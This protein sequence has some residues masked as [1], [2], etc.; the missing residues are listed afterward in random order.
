MLECANCMK[1]HSAGTN[2]RCHRHWGL[3]ARCGCLLVGASGLRLRACLG[4]EEAAPTPDLGLASCWAAAAV[5]AACLLVVIPT[6]GA[7]AGVACRLLFA[8]LLLPM[9]MLLVG[10]VFC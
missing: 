2:I 5:A 1:S 4:L 9:E 6:A 8:A 10:G 7:G 3:A